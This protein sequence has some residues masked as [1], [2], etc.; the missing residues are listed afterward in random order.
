MFK[1]SQLCGFTPLILFVFVV[2]FSMLYAQETDSL[3]Y[4]MVPIPAGEFI[5]GIEGDGD[6]SPA[7]QV[8]LDSFSIGKHEVTNAQY[9]KFCTE[10]DRDLPFFWGKEDFR[11]GP[12]FPDHP[13]VSVTWSDAK[14]YAEWKGMRLPTEAEWEC[15]ARGGLVG[16][17][18][19][20]A[21][22]IEP[23]MAN[24]WKSEGTEPVGSYP[25]NG[26]N[27]HDMAGN[28]LEWV[29]D[30][31]D[32]D[33]YQSSPVENPLGPEKGKFRVVRGG[34]WHTGPGC[35]KVHYRNGLKSNW[36]DF[37]VGFRCAKDAK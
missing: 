1:L 12:D 11:C 24:Y 36:A 34:G 14:A 21:D 13:V 18:Y 9:E 5:M 28:A 10:T 30:K 32:M 23:A 29:S 16:M 26:L 37:N 15:A 3:D 20:N 7:H 17:N 27:L 31:Y 6:S 19:P 25:P 2:T 4:E 22:E 33:Y 8:R 35:I